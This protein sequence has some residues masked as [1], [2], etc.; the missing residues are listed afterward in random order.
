MKFNKKQML[1]LVVASLAI[2]QVNAAKQHKRM[3]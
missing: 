3:C 1:G 2:F